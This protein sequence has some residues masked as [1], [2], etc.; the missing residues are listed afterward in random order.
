MSSP[1]FRLNTLFAAILALLFVLHQDFW[2][3]DN[4]T[5]V[6]G[7]PAG[8][9]YHLAYCG[10]VSLVFWVFLYGRKP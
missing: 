1:L 3:R 7:L 6:A 8:L 5:L 4:A 2:L 9:L 10:M